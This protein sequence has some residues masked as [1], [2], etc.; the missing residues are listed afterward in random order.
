V[1]SARYLPRCGKFILRV[2]VSYIANG[3]NNPKLQCLF[4]IKILALEEPF[5]GEIDL[6][7]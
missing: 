2:V 5:G 3:V 6:K 4:P 7:E 1:K